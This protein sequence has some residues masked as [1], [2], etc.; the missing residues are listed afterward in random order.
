MASSNEI[1]HE[2]EFCNSWDWFAV[3]ENGHI[4]HFDTGSF[5]HLPRTVKGSRL[6]TEK[7]AYYFTKEAQDICGFRV[8]DNVEFDFGGWSNV[9]YPDLFP[10]SFGDMARKGVYSHD[11]QNVYTSSI[12]YLVT[13]PDRPLNLAELPED[14]AELVSR[15]RSPFLFGQTSHFKETD[16]LEW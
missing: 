16:T 14:I 9:I 6:E 5:R 13:I 4:G 2:E 1:N 7:V 12:Y 15:V 11:T 8:R 10:G 3:D